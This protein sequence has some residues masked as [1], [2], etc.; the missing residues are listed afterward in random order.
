MNSGERWCPFDTDK[1]EAIINISR[2]IY[3]MDFSKDKIVCDIGCGN[4]LGSYLY[5]IVA[6]KVY[7]VDHSAEAIAHAKKYPF[8]PDKVEFIQQDLEKNFKL[9]EH[10]ILIAVEFLEHLADPQA[11]LQAQTSRELIFSLPKNSLSISTWH[12][13]DIKDKAD[14]ETLLANSGYRIETM[15][16]Q[17]N[18]W[19]H[20]H[21]IKL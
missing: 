9:P 10:D 16:V 18:L 2:Y 6:K 19:F 21:A 4:G 15:G 14:V 7:A 8:S 12:K 5:S 1:N 17:E 11:F 20:G 3:G 13:Y